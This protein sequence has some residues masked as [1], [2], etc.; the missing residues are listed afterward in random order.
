MFIDLTMEVSERT[1]VWPGDPKAEIKTVATLDKDGWNERRVAFNTHFSTHI[2]APFHMRNDGKKLD[3]FA[4]ESFIGHAKIIDVRGVSEIKAEHVGEVTGASIVLFWTDH[5]KKAFEPSFFENNPVISEEAAQALVDQGVKIVGI[6]SY[7]PDNEPFPAHKT[8]FA[9]NIRIV[10]NLV[11][12]DQVYPECKLI[13]APLN[14]TQADGAP[15]RVIAEV[16][17]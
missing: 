5:T 15:C 4:I 16:K 1:P 8:L 6:D 2:D 7:T 11:N 10:E 3:E 9:N 14:L 17:S 13:I 12:L